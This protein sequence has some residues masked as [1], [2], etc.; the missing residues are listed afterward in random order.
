MVKIPPTVQLS[1]MQQQESGQALNNR[2][3][4]DRSLNDESVSCLSVDQPLNHK[5]VSDQS[6]NQSLNGQL[7]NYSLLYLQPEKQ[8]NVSL[9]QTSKLDP[10]LNLDQP[11]KLDPS[12]SLDRINDLDETFRSHQ[13]VESRLS[14]DLNAKEQPVNYQLEINKSK[15]SRAA[16]SS[17]NSVSNGGES[18]FLSKREDLG[19]KQYVQQTRRDF[20]LAPDTYQAVHHSRARPELSSQQLAHQGSLHPNSLHQNGLRSS[21]EH[22]NLLY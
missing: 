21:F 2:I 19:V 7:A 22:R 5:S 3:L 4:K 10:A 1:E 13:V 16:S 11:C 18:L 14:K 6:V 15:K 12:F 8:Q 17:L 20:T 9:G